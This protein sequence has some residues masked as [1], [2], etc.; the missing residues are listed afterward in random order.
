MSK[1]YAAVAA[2]IAIGLVVG[3]NKA[4]IEDKL[5]GND[6]SGIIKS[7]VTTASP[8]T[9]PVSETQ[10]PA[11]IVV[12]ENIPQATIKPTAKPEPT[13]KQSPK[14]TPKSTPKATAKP[15]TR[16]APSV[17]PAV[18]SQAP[19]TVTE[20]PD[21]VDVVAATEAVEKDYK[22]EREGYYVPEN[23]NTTAAATNEPDVD[24]YS[25]AT[26]QPSDKY[27]YKEQATPMTASS[28][29]IADYL[30][31]SA[32]DIDAVVS[33]LNDLGV[34]RAKGLYMTQT[35]IFYELLIRLEDINVSYDYSLKYTT[36]D[37][38]SFKILSK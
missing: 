4:D 38:I 15:V 20:K 5:N 18:V 11:E 36:G 30:L 37:K 14:P 12:N 3:L 8:T 6:G 9:E 28:S 33:V 23:E 21:T 13:Q 35:N 29:A 31:V 19:Q 17:A 24:S 16:S 22:I 32:K 25:L 26:A 7:A 1:R 27:S 10:I 2:C 34:A